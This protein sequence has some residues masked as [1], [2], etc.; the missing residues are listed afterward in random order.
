MRAGNEL[1]RFLI[2]CI[3]ITFQH[4][5]SENRWHD[6]VIVKILL[7]EGFKGEMHSNVS[8]HNLIRN[9]THKVQTVITF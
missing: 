1:F 5:G 6:R 9:D 3:K 7:Q 2:T 4:T 8:K